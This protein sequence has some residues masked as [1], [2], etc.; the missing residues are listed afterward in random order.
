MEPGTLHGVYFFM[1]V[2]VQMELPPLRKL[3]PILNNIR[4][5]AILVCTLRGTFFD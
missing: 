3:F 4:C 5:V 1:R 2:Y